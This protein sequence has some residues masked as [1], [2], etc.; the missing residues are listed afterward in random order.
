MSF[1]RAALV[2]VPLILT[3]WGA[4]LAQS[5]PAPTDRDTRRLIQRFAQDAVVVPG[6]WLEGQFDYRNLPDNSDRYDLD[7]LIAFHA[8]SNVEA[9]MQ[10]GYANLNA[11]QPPD[12][13]GFS[14]IDI[15]GK[16]VFPGGRNRVALGGLLKIPTADE[17]K[18]L[19]TGK[20]DLEAFGAWRGNFEGVTLTANLGVR[21]NGNPDNP[22]LTSK[23]SALLGAA[24]LLPLSPASTFLVEWSFE[25][26]RFE[27][28]SNDSQLTPAFQMMF[29]GGKGGLR[30]GLAIPLSDGAPDWQ[31]IFG[32]FYTY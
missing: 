2:V 28:Y 30:G 11:P 25:T 23:D 14:D 15:Y 16:Y 21:F 22:A 26:S 20:R 31:A 5:A 10:F 4:V 3:C 1:R 17:N 9:G 19:G 12:G 8:G 6:G 24:I 27:G 7:A 13:S 18:G 29:R 32:A